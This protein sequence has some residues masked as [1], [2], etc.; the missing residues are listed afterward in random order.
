MSNATAA[1]IFFA[2]DIEFPGIGAHFEKHIKRGCDCTSNNSPLLT[3]GAECLAGNL[4]ASLHRSKSGAGW[5]MFSDMITGLSD[6]VEKV[7]DIAEAIEKEI[8]LPYTNIKI[9]N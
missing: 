5:L 4:M 6:S 2:Y 9:S 7:A 8:G 3:P 1:P